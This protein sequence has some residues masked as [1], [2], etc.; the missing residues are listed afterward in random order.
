MSG[1]NDPQRRDAAPAR[2]LTLAIA[3]AVLACVVAAVALVRGGGGATARDA[4]VATEGERDDSGRTP[5]SLPAPTRGHG[6]HTLSGEVVDVS[7]AAVA[8]AVIS[9]EFRLGPGVHGKPPQTGAGLSLTPEVAAKSGTDG[10]FSL[11]GLL[12][13][14]YRLHIAGADV[15][16]AEVRFVDVPGEKLRVVVSRKVVV[17]GRVV[18]GITPVVG[19]TVYMQ[20]SGKGDVIAVTTTAGGVFEKADMPAGTVRVWAVDAAR[21]LASPAAEVARLGPGP[22]D[23]L[24]LSMVPATRV[25]GRV[26]D[27]DGRGVAGATVVA[28][29]AAGSEPARETV[30][31]DG[32]AFEVVGL[33][34]GN[35]LA[36][37]AAPGYIAGDEVQ[38]AA[39]RDQPLVLTVLEGGQISGQVVDADGDP[40]QGAVIAAYADS[41][42]GGHH[43]V[44][45]ATQLVMAGG[46]TRF[47][48]R[49]ELGVLLGPIPYPPPPGAVHVRVAVPVAGDGPG[50]APAPETKS[51]FVTGAGG[52]FVIAGLEP[53]TYH[54]IAKA[55]ELAAGQSRAIKVDVGE[56]AGDV[57]IVLPRGVRITGEVKDA[58]GNP[59]A[60]AIVA[61][62]PARPR[63]GIT[64]VSA[65]ADGQGRYQIGPLTGTVVL[66]ASATD[67]GRA[68]RKVKLPG[69][70]E[71]P[72]TID[73]SFV[74]GGAGSR[75]FGQVFDPGGFG[76]GGAQVTA[77]GPRGEHRVARTDENGRF[78]MTGMAAGTYVVHVTHGDYPPATARIE[79]E[80][81]GEVTMSYGGGLRGE[82]RDRQTGAAIA[83]AP[84]ILR[85]PKKQKRTVMTDDRGEFSALALAAGT[86]TVVV[87]APGYAPAKRTAAIEAGHRVGQVTVDDLRLELVRGATLAGTV[88]DGWGEL[89]AG[90]VVSSGGAHAKTDAGGRFR[91]RDVPAGD[92][93]VTIDYR[94]QHATEAISVLPGDRLATVDLRLP[95]PD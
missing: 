26:I 17:S 36:E 13:G 7:G 44:S 78:S 71:A 22:F 60:G 14:R 41:P 39:D 12:P 43:E 58:A 38:F 51:V 49:G 85:G 68:R 82:V 66:T 37:A 81:A 6:P 34:S 62:A 76:L 59:L 8:G 52:E 94:D 4:A 46:D 72:A 47:I 5:P 21:N 10:A 40:V 11:V 35:W 28:R 65:V 53:G 25:R 15:F 67:H 63:L 73:E 57:R 92:I 90:A 61:W 86:W 30:T 79:A 23:P 32:G 84:V 88:R 9:A 95:R 20:G 69:G 77:D 48:P 75:I 64:P 1:A 89:V 91:L 31:G 42:G 24:V 16:P 29:D 3:G 33:L 27:G 19:A 50:D 70:E 56:R 87:D 83:S 18:D 93:T 2:A 74:L 54:V 45:A 80:V 55:P